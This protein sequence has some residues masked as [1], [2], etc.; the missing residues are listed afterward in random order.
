MGLRHKPN[1]R[2]ERMK[3]TLLIFAL[4]LTLSAACFALTA[5]GDDTQSNPGDNS[6]DD[7]TKPEPEKD[8]MKNFKFTSTATSCEITGLYDKTV[9]ELVIPDYV[10]SIG[11]YAF[12]YCT[13]LT[14]VTIPNSVTSIGSYAF[15]GCTS[16]TSVTIGNSVTSIGDDAFA[17]CI[18]LTS[19]T[20][21]NSVKS[22]G[23][24]AFA[25]CIGLTSVTIPNSVTSIGEDAF[26][27][28][29]K[30]VEVIDLSSLNITAGS[31]SNG[32]VGYYA[33]E[34]HKGESKIVNY[35]DY[36]FYTYDGVNYL[37][38]YVG[39][40]T[41]LVLP[42]SYKGENYKIYNYAFYGCTSLTSVTIPDSV[43]SIGEWAFYNCDSLTSMT[44]PDSVTS[45][46]S[47]AFSGCHKLVEVIDLSSLKITAGSSYGY[48]GYY[49]KEVHKGES[50]IVNYND[51]LFYTYDGVNYLLGYVG[52][53]TA[54]VLPE[55]Y[56]GENYEI[57]NYAF[58]Y[59]TS[60]KSVTIPNSVTSI[61]DD[62]FYSCTCLTSVT[63]GNSV[64]SI[65]EEA[66][67][68]CSSLTSVTIPDSVTSIGNW[69]FS[70]CTSLTSVTIPDSVTSIG[71]WAFY[72]CT[73]LTI[74]CEAESKPSGWDSKWNPSDRPVVW[75]YKG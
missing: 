42:E 32:Y 58:A 27:N 2:R 60:L 21:G 20:I 46:G 69:A 40:D 75:G 8:E 17:Y 51:Y 33:I 28:C 50:K 71:D 49:A 52:K 41:A 43:T 26:Y 61:G 1:K 25:Y 19:V 66:F 54:L 15:R 65:G 53:D 64:T 30:L 57:Y 62:A 13:S 38:G 36:L 45:I 70:A 4:I 14:S 22:I 9:T 67:C 34:V 55:S 39:E 68:F 56:K 6:A 74:Y 72:Y 23:R 7:G 29:Y 18:S 44:I 37:F 59:C 3:K 5:C 11:D 24:E 63:I 48:V 35:N 16:L 47:F 73:S 12:S 10:T 31:S